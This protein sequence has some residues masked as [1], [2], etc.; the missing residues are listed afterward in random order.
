MS[1]YSATSPASRSLDP[2][3]AL[4][5]LFCRPQTAVVLFLVAVLQQSIGHHNA[6]N[7][8]LFT[9]CEKVLDGARPYTDIIETN[10]PASFLLYMPAALLARW[11]QAPMELI[12]SV[13]VFAGALGCIVFSGAIL[14]TGG[15]LR[16]DETPLIANAAVLSLILMPGFSFAERE[17]IA[18]FL[19][20]P[21]LALYAVRAEAGEIRF[22]QALAAGLL[23]GL[24]MAIKPHFVFAVALPLLLM[25]WRRRSLAP[26]LRVE[27]FA[28]A[29]VVLVYLASIVL[30][31]PGFFD[32]LPTLLHAYAPLREPFVELVQ[33][34]WLLV[35]LG[36]LA[37]IGY[38]LRVRGFDARVAVAGAAS[39]GFL[40]AFLVQGKGW[41]NHGLPG[42]ALAF[43]ALAIAVA[44]GLFSVAVGRV[45]AAWTSLRRLNLFIMLP[46]ILGLPVLFGTL[47]QFTMRE[48][49]PGVAEIIRRIG[50]AQPKIITVSPDLD[51]GHPLVRRVGGVWS[52]QPHSLWLMLYAQLLIDSGRGDSAQLAGFIARDA[53]MFADAVAASHPDF[54]LVSTGKRVDQMLAHPDIAA[55]M[56]GYAA[57]ETAGEITIWTPKRR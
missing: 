9:M 13:L 26:A 57:T 14:K 10:P 50:P 40:A 24:V 55:A 3:G 23:A 51:L 20:L 21:M 25:A 34:S 37:A 52:G 33:H 15:L 39:A 35:N 38:V 12:V 1:S 45:D 16:A 29:A 18:A 53:R 28:A 2:G 46:A 5:R 31:F 6:D 44:P 54:I 56:R 41:V 43:L 11:L 4:A 8:W 36:L 19:V 47:V 30:L 49:Y 7:S 17:H 27:N 48:E 42:V 32:V 22:G